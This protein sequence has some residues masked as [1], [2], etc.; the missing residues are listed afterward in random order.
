MALIDPAALA[1]AMPNE[2]P[3]ER[4]Q[5]S[6]LFTMIFSTLKTIAPP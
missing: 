1:M 6:P 2:K 5:K 3:S 4:K